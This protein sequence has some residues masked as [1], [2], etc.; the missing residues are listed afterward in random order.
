MVW[1]N[2]QGSI[3]RGAMVVLLFW[4][5][6]AWT[7]TPAPIPITDPADRIVTVHENGKATRCRILETWQL[8]D[9]RTAQLLEAI[10]TGERITIVDEPGTSIDAMKN[11]RAVPKR[12]FAWG[13]GRRMP[14]EGS[15]LPP[16]MQIDSGMIVKNDTPPP[17][18]AVPVGPVIVNRLIDEKALGARLGCATMGRSR[19][20][21][22]RR[23]GRR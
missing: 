18:D 10:E 9:R 7:Q 2:W 19:S 4:S 21:T 8:G 3:W 12:I 6:L 17:I 23:R 13:Q 11:P 15:P 1:S 14:P 16:H 5:G 20:W 22:R